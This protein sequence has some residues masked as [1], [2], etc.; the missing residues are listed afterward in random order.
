MQFEQQQYDPG[1]NVDIG[2]P[3]T[4][5]DIE[6]QISQV[7]QQQAKLDQEF[8]NQ[9]G[10]NQKMDTQNLQTTIKNEQAALE[11]S[12][13][14]MQQVQ[15]PGSMGLYMGLAQAGMSAA[16]AFQQ[17]SPQGPDLKFGEQEGFD[18]YLDKLMA[19]PYNPSGGSQY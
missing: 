8:L 16:S 14:Q 10:S 6:Q 19:E 18:S 2:Q 12:Q 15:N 7:A 9:M 11:Q 13:K 5:P 1:V 3:L 4:A 17:F